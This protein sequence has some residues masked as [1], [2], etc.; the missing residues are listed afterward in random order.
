[1]RTVLVAVLVVLLAGSGWAGDTPN[2]FDRF[3][4]P[5]HKGNQTYTLEEIT[6]ASGPPPGIRGATYYAP[7]ISCGKFTDG[8]NSDEIGDSLKWLWANWIS[9]FITG[10]NHSK[11]RV[12][13]TDE[14]GHMAWLAKYCRE[15]PLDK[16]IE[17][18]I[19]LDVELDARVGAG[20]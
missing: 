9:G 6:A 12:T 7:D 2:P 13:H 18:V 8:L 1:M 17:A 4:P 16:F 11:G 19:A 5:Q 3:D 10:A 15:N 20:R 14:E